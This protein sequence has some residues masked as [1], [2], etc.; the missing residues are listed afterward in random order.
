MRSYLKFA[1]NE[2]PFIGL[3]PFQYGDHGYFFGRTDELD[4]LEPQVT[5][6]RFVAIVGGSGSGKSSLIRAGLQARLEKV[7]DHRWCWIEMHPADA[8]I[9]KLA[10]ALAGLTR[11]TGDLLEASADRFERVLTKTSFG[12]AEALAQ[13]PGIERSRVLLLV[14]QFEE[15]FRFANLRSESNLDAATAAERRDEA[16]AFVRLLLT[17]KSLQAPIHV[18]VTMRS[19]FIGDCARFHGLSEAVS[20]SQFLV[21]GMTRDQREDVIRKPVEVAGGRIDSDLVQ[22]ALNDSNE[23]PDQLPILQHTMMRCWE[24]A[25]RRGKQGVDDR[26]YLTV[27]DYAQVGGVEQALSRHANEILEALIRYSDSTTIGLQLATKRVFQALTETDQDG[28]SVRSPQRLRDLVQYV[29][30]GDASEIDSATEK[31]TRTVVGRFASPDCSFLRVTPPVDRNDG[32]IVDADAN[33][34]GDSIIDIGHEALIRRWDKLKAEGEENWMREEQED[35]ERY[36]ALLRYAANGAT[37]P[38]EDLTVLER[39][40]IKRAPNPFWARRYTKHNADSFEKAREVLTR[41]RAKA[42]AAIEESQRYESRVIALA[43]DAIRLPRTLNGAADSLALALKKPPNLPIIREH[44]ELLYNGLSELRERRRIQTPA[45]FGKQ[46]FALSFAPTGKLLAAAVPGN[47]LFYD[48][49]DGKL[50]HSEKTTGGWA[51]ALRWSPDGKRIYVGTSPV[52]RILAACSIEK[53]RG[54]LADCGG[55]KWHSVDIGSEEHPAGTGAWTHDGQWMIVAG[56]Q[57]RASLWDASKGRFKRVVLG[58][59]CLQGNPL[60]Y[61]FTDVAASAD[62]ERFALGAVSGKIHIVNVALRGRNGPCIEFEKSLDSIDKNANPFPYS[63]VFDPQNPD[64][65][66]AAY[67][68]S[69]FMAL[70]K[71]DENTPCTFGDEQSGPVW[72]VAF[73][74]GGEF[75]AS[76]ANDAAVRLWNRPESDSAVQLRGHLA[77]IFSLDISRENGVVASGSFDGTIRIWAKDSPLCPGLLPKST[78]MPSIADAFNVRGSQISVTGNDGKTYSVTLPREFGEAS[79]A[80]VSANGAGIAV[81]PRS[82]QPVLFLNLS[83]QLLTASVALPGVKAEWTAVAFIENNTRIAAKTKQGRIFSWPFCSDVRSLEQLAQKHLPLVRDE[84]GLDRRLE[85]R[86]SIFRR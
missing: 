53:L 18:V 27:D 54:Y 40:W 10:L 65:L 74:P 49:D 68:P 25:L 17:A 16:T 52:G 23:D 4:E 43:A 62:G 56:W 72:R 61:L 44:V 42:D 29:R 1:S 64:R 20:R 28:R 82:G 60:D 5:Q 50:L 30:A 46:V 37:I 21:P 75:M 48:T 83:N 31:A 2:W 84:N 45:E 66:L 69:P 71:V 58:D 63:L 41:S 51:M 59:D 81:V 70:W 85:V 36:R 3:R 34:D 47:L 14:D 26:P 57:R 32:S 77:S 22:Q 33:I 11:E 15:L 67:A 38:A 13:I 6:K 12:I 73:D 80:A 76:A 24:Q 78:S 86:A 55:Q 79:A 35:A 8:P 9:R 39:W 19:D 7:P